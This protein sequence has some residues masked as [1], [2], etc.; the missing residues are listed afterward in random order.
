MNLLFPKKITIAI[1][2][3]HKDFNLLINLLK[4]IYK[5]WNPHEIDSIKIILNDTIQYKKEFDK[6]IQSCSNDLFK[7]EKFYLYEI[8]SELDSFDWHSQ[9]LAKCIISKKITT[10]W[11]LL[12]DCKDFYT[13]NVS[14]GDCF[15]PTGKAI[16]HLDHKRY[17]NYPSSPNPTSHWGF[18][19]FSLAYQSSCKIWGLDDRNYK[20]YHLPYLTPFFVKTKM[21]SDMVDELQSMFRFL[22][23]TIFSLHL[24]GQLF[25]TEFLLYNGY[26]TAKNNLEDYE[27][28]NYNNRKFFNSINQS[29][30]GR[31]SDGSRKMSMN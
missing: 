22:F 9:Q 27:D 31:N 7:I 11:Y 15:T 3:F 19:P 28:W 18:G 14:L 1:I 23:P 25:V 20:Q 8:I 13:K 2:T 21:M 6:I 17:N 24:D 12:H 16:M 5:N 4:S 10:D 30:E 26:C 29:L